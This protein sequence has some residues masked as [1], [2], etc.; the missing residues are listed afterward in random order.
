MLA[1][2]DADDPKDE[3]D[4]PERR[5]AQEEPG[6]AAPVVPSG[7]P[8]T[9]AGGR[10]W[11]RRTRAIVAWV[12]IV[13]VSLLVPLSVVT[14]WAVHTITD[15][16]TY[17]A[18]LAPVAKEKVITDYVA[19]RATDALFSRL[20]VQN[21]IENALPSKAQF[22]A[23]PITNTLKGFVTTQ[24]KKVLQSTWFQNLWN[25]V[26]RRTHSAVVDVLSGNKPP[27]QTK[28]QAVAADLTPVLLQ[29]I[30]ALDQ[31][32]VTAFDSLVP[33]LQAGHVLTL[34]VVSPAQLSRA[35]R[36]FQLA[37][38]LGYWMPLITFFLIAAGLAVA[39]NR[40]KALLRMAIGVLIGTLVHLAL[41][42]LG[43]TFVINH[44]DKHNV[45][46]SVT[47]ALYDTLTRFLTDTLREV[48][49]VAI[50][51][52]VVAW[53]VGPAR[54]AR[55]LRRLIFVGLRGIWRLITRL[56]PSKASA[57]VTAHAK[58]V[59]TWL[60]SYQSGLRLGGLV[61]AGIVILFFGNLTVDAIWGTFLAV[62]CYLLALEIVFFVARRIA[63]APSLPDAGVDAQ[64]PSS[65]PG[66]APDALEPARPGGR[67]ADS[68]ALPPGDTR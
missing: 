52:A 14:V 8:F 41:L 7:S 13:L 18:T 54:P 33:R 34:N 6:P 61:I 53:L 50:V 11:V 28:A 15:T 44:A 10:R 63:Q 17:V 40:R 4:L 12:L 56:V 26:N 48:V 58:K 3:S 19:V 46:P 5:D 64:P 65:E 55:Q 60:L 35:Q 51:V 2:P 16:D 9:S 67:S 25:T 29:G 66:D 42:A 39:L 62:V 32:G 27:A 1:M 21:R 68:A 22:V 38:D 24:F 37:K 47:S 30:S 49:I 57:Q 31:H 43:R 23:A 20:N 36:A 59:A 45:S